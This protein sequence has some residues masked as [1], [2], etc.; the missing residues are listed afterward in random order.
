MHESGLSS[1]QIE[2]MLQRGWKLVNEA[3]QLRLES[4]ADKWNALI[5]EQ[6]P[7]LSFAIILCL[8]FGIALLICYDRYTHYKQEHTDLETIL[9]T[10]D[11]DAILVKRLT[12]LIALIAERDNLIAE[13]TL[14]EAKP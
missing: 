8:L 7:W 13:Q 10:D 2:Y 11:T 12:A 3:T 6:L 5:I 9:L 1:V 4:D 14:K